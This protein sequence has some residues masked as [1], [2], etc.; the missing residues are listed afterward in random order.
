MAAMNKSTRKYI[1]LLD[2]DGVVADFVGKVRSTVAA[3]GHHDLLVD[4][5]DFT[6]KLQDDAPDIYKHYRT[7]SA[8]ANWCS[9]IERYR[10]AVAFVK[11]LRKLGDVVAVTSPLSHCPTWAYERKEWLVERL[12]FKSDDIV[13]IKRKDL[14]VGDFMIDDHY[15]N[16]EAWYTRW[17]GAHNDGHARSILVGHD[18]NAEHQPD[19]EGDWYKRVELSDGYDDIV[20][21]ISGVI[22]AHAE[23]ITGRDF[24]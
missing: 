15:G 16:I 21:H 18:Y 24:Y 6:S 23:P 12:G 3:V 9:S 4:R 2:V 22:A 13:S 14:V 5:F 20:Q 10:G 17:R 19:E 11:A 7:E 1:I 8:A